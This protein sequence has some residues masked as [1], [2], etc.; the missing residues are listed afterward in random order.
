MEGRVEYFLERFGELVQ[1]GHNG[2][3]SLALEKD[4]LAYEEEQNTFIEEKATEEEKK[5]LVQRLLADSGIYFY[6]LF[7]IPMGKG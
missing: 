7:W 4:W 5:D 1:R 6:D 2:E 3:S